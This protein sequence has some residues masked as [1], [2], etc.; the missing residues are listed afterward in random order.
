LK[1]LQ[2]SQNLN[3]T[4]RC[5]GNGKYTIV[6]DAGMGNW[7]LF[8]RPIFQ[9]LKK[10]TRVCIIDRPGY[11]VNEVTNNPRDSKTMAV[12]I[13]KALEKNGISENIIIVGH[14]LGGLNVRMYQSLFPEKVKGMVLL[15]AAHPKQFQRLPKAFNEMLNNQ[16]Q[17]LDKVIKIAQK[18]YL[19]YSKGKIPTF[20]MPDSLLIDY[21]KVTTYPEYYYTM[22]MEAKYFTESLSQVDS[23]SGLQDLPLLVIGSKNSMDKNILPVKTNNYPYAEHNG[24]WFQLQKELSLLSTNTTFIESDANHYL[25]ITDSEMV[26]GSID[27]FYK[28]HFSE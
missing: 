26:S 23:L 5:E 12:E 25:N 7:S 8:Y 4:C 22:K 20:G 24:A 6:L 9:Q 14:S 28:K 1:T 2:V 11:N 21:Y 16:I 19:K 3:A 15:D 17:S 27:K 18:G 10:T 13:D